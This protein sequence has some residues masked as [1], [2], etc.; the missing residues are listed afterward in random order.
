M[1]F[2]IS[3]NQ[4]GKTR[5]LQLLDSWRSAKPDDEVEIRGGASTDGTKAMLVTIGDDDHVLTELE[6]AALISTLQDTLRACPRSAILEGLDTLMHG[7]QGAIDVLR[8][9][10]P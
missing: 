6:A 7:L 5:A 2:E 9:E 4:S 8:S 10:A 3:T 1:T